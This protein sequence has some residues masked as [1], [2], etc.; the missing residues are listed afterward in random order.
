[1]TGAVV[2]KLRPNDPDNIFGS[3]G[4]GRIQLDCPQ[5]AQINADEMN[6][7]RT[8]PITFHRP[9][10]RPDSTLDVDRLLF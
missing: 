6:R 7:L 9:N 8:L 3:R 10:H 1:M 2:V 4:K 5:I